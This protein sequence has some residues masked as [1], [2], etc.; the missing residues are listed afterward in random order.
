MDLKDI[1]R[2]EQETAIRDA[3]FKNH[4]IRDMAEYETRAEN[5]NNNF[6]QRI[7]SKIHKVNNYLGMMIYILKAPEKYNSQ[8]LDTQGFDKMT[9]TQRYNLIRS[10]AEKDKPTAQTAN[11]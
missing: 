2:I 7:T 11:P 5:S 10:L 3:T 1:L 4:D 6:L 9:F 8:A